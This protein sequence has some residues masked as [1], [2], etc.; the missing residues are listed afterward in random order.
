[1]DNG[2]PEAKEE[3]AW[4]DYTRASALWSL[5][6]Q[7]HNQAAHRWKTRDFRDGLNQMSFTL[8]WC[9][10][11]APHVSGT[12]DLTFIGIDSLKLARAEIRIRGSLRNVAEAA[13]C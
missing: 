1:M 11:L 13:S 7:G 9:T 6:D 12:A 4:L 5:S 3:G 8:S 2:Y 10:N